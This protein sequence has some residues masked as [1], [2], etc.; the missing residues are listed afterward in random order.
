MQA[1]SKKSALLSLLLLALISSAPSYAKGSCPATACSMDVDCTSCSVGQTINF[2]T[3]CSLYIQVSMCEEEEIGDPTARCDVICEEIP[4]TPAT[5]YYNGLRKEGNTW[6][7]DAP[8]LPGS[9]PLAYTF[10][11]GDVG[12]YKRQTCLDS[13]CTICSSP[14]QTITVSP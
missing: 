3:E 7:V 12:E 6:V 11:S 4:F 13:N 1:I 14:L 9:N 8:C 10:Q 2:E 5:V